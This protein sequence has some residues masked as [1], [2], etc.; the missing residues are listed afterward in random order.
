MQSSMKIIYIFYNNLLKILMLQHLVNF[1]FA[2]IFYKVQLFTDYK[3][4]NSQYSLS[5]LLLF[6]ETDTILS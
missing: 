3:N 5:F 4:I 6:H 1:L 2:L